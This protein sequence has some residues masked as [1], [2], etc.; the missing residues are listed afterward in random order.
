M[1]ENESFVSSPPQG[2]LAM[3][4]VRLVIKCHLVKEKRKEKSPLSPGFGEE[5]RIQNT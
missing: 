1:V 4:R 2:N 3:E 5:G